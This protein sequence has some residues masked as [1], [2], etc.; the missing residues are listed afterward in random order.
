MKMNKVITIILGMLFIAITVQ[1]QSIK[2]DKRYD[3]LLQEYQ[4]GERNYNV[5]PYLANTARTMHDNNTANEIASDYIKGYLDKL[6]ESEFFTKKNLQFLSSF[7]SE[8]TSKDAVFSFIYHQPERT[9]HILGQK[10]ANQL[11]SFLIT[12]EE[13]N[14]SLKQAKKDNETPDWNKILKAIKR[15]YNKNYAERTVLDS[16]IIWYDGKKDW[17]LDIKYNIEKIDKYGVDTSGWGLFFLN[18][19]IFSVIFQYSDNKADLNKGAKWMQI[20]L[21]KNPD[22]YTSMD[23]YANLLYKMGQTNEALVVEEKALDMDKEA[24]V[25]QNRKPD[26]VFQETIERMKKGLP[27]WGQS[28]NQ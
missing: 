23:T 10:I 6:N 19:M 27:T 11:I 7:F 14:P 5:M 12:K 25:K 17:P 22:D 2:P 20:I 15:K 1:A 16:K 26:P 13:I 28:Y 24:S 18:N 4:Q 8:V 21:K 9:D 3:S